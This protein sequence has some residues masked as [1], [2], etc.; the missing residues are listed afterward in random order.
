MT[1]VSPSYDLTGRAALVTGA[2][3]GLGVTFATALAEAGADVV[4]AARR[5][6][7]LQEVAADIQERTGRRALAV[8]CD[9][10]DPDQVE[11]AVQEAVASWAGSTSPWR[12]PA[13]SRR[14]S[15]CRRSCRPTSGGSPS[16]ST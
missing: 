8:A 10:T 13:R 15:R 11:A 14:G 2:S 1:R 3:S 6:D 16:T 12:A 7:K 9:V 5:T 4:L